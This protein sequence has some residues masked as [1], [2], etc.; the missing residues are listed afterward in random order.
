MNVFRKAILAATC[1]GSLVAVA[2][3]ATAQTTLRAVMH[4]DLKILDPIWTT[5]YIV[6]NH[7]YMIYDTLLAQDEKGDIKLQMLEK[8]ETA[9]DNKSYTFT[10]R[11]G[12]L[13]HDGKP[14]TAEDC[15][16]SIKRWGAKDAMGQKMMS[17]V[18]DMPVVDPGTFQMVLSAPTG[19][20][21]TA[22]GK[23]SSAVPFM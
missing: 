11:S 18:K 4:S 16:A 21:L 6:R 20:V 15:V 22:L 1:V 5:A 8:Y 14:V 17:F 10:L 2:A 23:P 9:P 13:W 19:L 7:G 3:P 12:L